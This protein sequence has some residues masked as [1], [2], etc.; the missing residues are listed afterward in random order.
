M[1]PVTTG[2]LWAGALA[3]VVGTAGITLGVERWVLHHDHEG[4]RDRDGHDEH[5][6]HPHAEGEAEKKADGHGG[7]DRVVLTP[8]GRANAGIELATA[9]PGKVDVILSLPGQVAINGEAVA[10]V[11]PRVSGTAR[12]VKKRLGD[13]V[14]R[15]ELLAL[16]DSRELSEISR[17]AR[18]SGERVKLAEANLTRTEKLF[19]EGITPEKD[20]L[21]AKQALAEAKIE[22]ESASQMLASTGTGGGGTYRL[23]A[24][25][26]GTI[27]E[28]HLTVGEVVK[29]DAT[30][31][32]IADLST[33]WVDVTVYSKDLAWIALGQPVRVRVD[34]IKEPAAG[35]IS[36]LSATASGEA[37]TTIARV[38]LDNRSGAWKPGLFVTSDVAIEQIDAAVVVPE[39][40]VQTLEGRP[41]VFVEDGDAFE[42][43]P[44]KLGHIGLDAGGKAKSREIEGGLRAGDRYVAKGAFVLK[45]ELGKGSAA[46]E[47]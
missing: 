6:G 8:E 15:G 10:H 36:F 20:L 21:T 35:T 23:V 7:E 38:L 26:D 28:K 13:S 5:E 12:E 25:L 31:F 41:V 47:H 42:A 17:E 45:A 22:Q 37:R 9:G 29:D 14:R 32:V 30:C 34:G 18:S 4:G 44:V 40:A 27:I 19:K 46:H 43:R 11:T 24:P 16:L 1:K 33:L 2:G 39:D 3:L